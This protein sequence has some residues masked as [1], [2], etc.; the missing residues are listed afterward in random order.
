MNDETNEWN[1]RLCLHLDLLPAHRAHPTAA[2][3][4][5]ATVMFLILAGVLLTLLV[6][7]LRGARL[8]RVFVRVLARVEASWVKGYTRFIQSESVGGETD[9]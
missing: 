4:A 8:I 3:A 6:P 7:A 5:P 1:G 2:A 9:G